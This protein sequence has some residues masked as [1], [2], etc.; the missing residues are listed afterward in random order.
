MATIMM[1]T[2]FR[3]FGCEEIVPYFFTAGLAIFFSVIVFKAAQ[4]ALFFKQ[5]FNE[6]LDPEKTFHLF[7]VVG[8]VNLAGVCFS[9]ILHLPPAAKIC[10]CT[11][12]CLWLGISLISFTGLFLLQKPE[13]RKVEDVAYGG[14]LY[15]VVGAQ[16]TAYLGVIVAEDAMRHI[17]LIQFFSFALWSVG[18]FLYLVFMG[19]IVM[20]MVFSKPGCEKAASSYWLNVG[21]A[22]LTALAGAAWFKQVQ[23]AGGP[24]ADLLPFSKGMSLFY[25]SIGLWWMPFLAILAARRQICA[26]ALTFTVGYWEATLALGVYAE[27]TLLLR[28]LFEG[29]ALAILSWCFFLAGAILWCFS[30]LFTV[31]HLARSSIWVPVN[32]LTIHHVVPHSFKLHGRLFRVKEVVS[33]WLDQTVQGAMQKKYCVVINNNLTCVISYNVLTKKWWLDRVENQH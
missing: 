12:I 17:V 22:A 33:E 10:W 30:T 8:A 1:V 26:K 11:A 27:G 32:D 16:S 23:G 13:D 25:W 2:A 14:W 15:A 5:A 29:Q 28:H 7:A 9:R 20:R 18:A 21:A 6:L 24:F 19:I 4:I 31:A 3:P